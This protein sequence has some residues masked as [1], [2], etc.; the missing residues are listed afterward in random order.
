[1]SIPLFHGIIKH[2]FAC[3][4]KLWVV[5]RLPAQPFALR[6]CQRER[7]RLALLLCFIRAL[8]DFNY[9]GKVIY[10]EHLRYLKHRTTNGC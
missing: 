8:R 5:Q 6:K 1:L 9:T 4:L 10:N 7:S 3:E 2:M